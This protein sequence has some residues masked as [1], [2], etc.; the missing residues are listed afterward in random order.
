MTALKATTKLELSDFLFSEEQITKAVDVRD[1][2][3]EIKKEEATLGYISLY[4]LKT[5]TAHSD[6]EL[7]KVEIRQIDGADWCLLFEHP[8]FQR[9]KPQLVPVSSLQEEND[10]TYFLLRN[11]QK[12]GPYEKEQ[13]LSMVEEKEILL[14]DMVSTNAGHTWMKLYQAEG[15]DRRTLKN[16]DQLPGLPFEGHFNKIAPSPSAQNPETEALSGL[17]YIGNV[18]R[19]KVVEREQ[20]NHYKDEVTKTKGNSSIYKWLL[21]LSVI[22]IGYFLYNIKNQLTSPFTPAP[23]PIGEQAEM[24]TPVEATPA[25]VGERPADRPLNQF[26]DSRR[27]GK[28]EEKS[29][30]PIVPNRRKSF[31]ES[32]KFQAIRNNDSDDGNYFYDNTSPIE[33][34]PVRSQVS[35]ETFDAPIGDPG[36]SGDVLFEEEISR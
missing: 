29:F 13:L 14:T 10:L 36:N 24:L 27:T 7:D 16:S 15:F 2:I 1:H 28:F 17:A 23:S 8:F 4:D 20:N 25:L 5:L 34:D 11:G 12:A 30:K 3:F 9:R 31:M 6:H 35:K 33:L 21:I 18:K 32:S 22:G 26:N 19:G